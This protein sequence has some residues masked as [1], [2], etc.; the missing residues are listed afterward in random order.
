MFDAFRIYSEKMDVQKI[1]L[2]LLAGG[3]SFVPSKFYYLTCHREENTKDDKT[4]LGILQ[5]MEEIDAPT[6]YP[7][8]PRN[9]KKALYLQRE[10]NISNVLFVEP[11]GY[12]ESTALVC[13]ADK[14][15]T[16]SGGLQRETFFAGKKCVTVFYI[17]IWP[18]TMVGNRNN[19]AKP[20]TA[21]ILEKLTLGQEVNESYQPF[22][23]GHAA[24]KV[25]TALE[26]V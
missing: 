1:R 14:I 24:E 22:G 16:D 4:L 12:L 25:V 11:V 13:H 6:I 9:R 7:V 10:K 17:P 8:H 23:D 20:T 15:V 26:E 5:A 2:N 18:E 21:D 19:L 3:T